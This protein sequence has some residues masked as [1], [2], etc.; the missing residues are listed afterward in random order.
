MLNN[1][2]ED[3]DDDGNDHVDNV[4]RA[5]ITCA[6]VCVVGTSRNRNVHQISNSSLTKLLFYIIVRCYI[7][8]FSLIT[9][10]LFYTIVIVIYHCYH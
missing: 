2:D 9:L 3:G 10:L 7:S 1:G 4:E 5:M 8:L 6:P